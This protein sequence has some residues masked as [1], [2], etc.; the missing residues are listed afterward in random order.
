MIMEKEFRQAEDINKRELDLIESAVKNKVIEGYIK[1]L[2][3][4]KKWVKL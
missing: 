1:N 3:R 4:I 2:R